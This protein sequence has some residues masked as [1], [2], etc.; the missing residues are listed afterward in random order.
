MRAPRRHGGQPRFGFD[1]DRL[2]LVRFDFKVQGWTEARAR[3]A[4]ERIA[5]DARRQSGTEAVAIVSGLPLYRLGRSA[6]L[7]DARPAFRT[8]VPTGRA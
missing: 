6:N 4:V 2:A 3:R 7:L 1:L 5:D 8:E